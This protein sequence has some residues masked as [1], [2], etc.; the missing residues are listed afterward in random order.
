M[1]NMKPNYRQASR[2]SG[3]TRAP[4]SRKTAAAPSRS[5]RISTEKARASSLPMNRPAFTRRWTSILASLSKKVG[6]KTLKQQVASTHHRLS[7][8]Q[9]PPS[10]DYCC[11]PH[12]AVEL[13]VLAALYLLPYTNFITFSS[14]LGLLVEGFPNAMYA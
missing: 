2:P 8:G 14:S 4:K 13:K 11:Y 3:P 10:A 1:E 7:I 9:L 6:K 5:K 12:E